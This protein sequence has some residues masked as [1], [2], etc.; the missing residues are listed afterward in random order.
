MDSISILS[1]EYIILKFPKKE[2]SPGRESLSGGVG[3]YLLRLKGNELVE[4]VAL[5]TT[6]P[7]GGV[8]VGY[9]LVAVVHIEPLRPL[10]GTKVPETVGDAIVVV[11]AVDVHRAEHHAGIELAQISNQIFQSHFYFSSFRISIYIL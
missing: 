1:C 4:V 11:I 2:N 6:G 7:P 8:L 9:L 5:V 10:N 3:C